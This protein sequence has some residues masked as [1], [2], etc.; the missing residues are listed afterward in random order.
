MTVAIVPLKGLDRAKQRLSGELDA[1]ARI[2][3]VAWMLARVLAACTA[4]HVVSRVV[5]V[6]GDAQGEQMARELG[7]E[8]LRERAPGL[9]AALAT[10]DEH[11][12]E[13]E[14]TL[15][16]AADLPLASG[17]DL[18]AMHAAAPLGDCVVVAPTRDGGTGALLRRP[19]DVVVPAY[20]PRS[21]RA[22]LAAARAAGVPA[23]RLD[24]PRLALD[25]DTPSALAA[26]REAG[27]PAPGGGA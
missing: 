21:A 7:A 8:P 14:S 16:V 3:L 22:H 18:D 1:G 20:G 26:L 15:V 11:L 10:A 9:N 25:I 4:S 24:L 13:A 23:V 5:V 19:P 27:L 17:R 2:E 12:R 6:T